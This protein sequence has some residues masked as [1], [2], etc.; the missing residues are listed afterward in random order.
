MIDILE[1]SK[2]L[3][4]ALASSSVVAYFYQK[5]LKRLGS[6]EAITNTLLQRLMDGANDVYGSAN[7]VR[8]RLSAIN[9]LLCEKDLSA[10]AIREEE[11]AL[12]SET[13][14]LNLTLALHRIYITKLIP[15]GGSQN[16]ITPPACVQGW[17]RLIVKRLDEG[18]SKE[19]DTFIRDSILEIS[20]NSENFDTDFFELC[21]AIE[22]AKNDILAGIVP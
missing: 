9:L 20:T 16:L 2:V 11:D 3:V 17:L 19:D 13:I 8:C 7:K 1:I 18:R 21:R 10:A 5:R 12:H 15:F 14:T 22:S 4:S 6:F